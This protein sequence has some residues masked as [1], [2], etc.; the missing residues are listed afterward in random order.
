MMP[1]KP[2]EKEM[3]FIDH[4]EE[5]RKRILKALVAV[6][7]FAVAAYFISD[8][9]I[10]I[11]TAPLRD[12]GVYFKAPTEAFMVRIKISIFAGA[13][14]AAPVVFYQLWMFIG[15]G[16]L[17]K[18]IKIIVAIVLSATVFF[19]AGGAFC[20]FLVVPVAV[21]LLLGFATENM[22]P[23]IMVGDYIS[24]VGMLVLAFGAVFELP[25]ASFILGR[26]GVISHKTLS[27]GRRYAL[28][29]I[30]IAA[31]ILTPTPDAF[32]QLMLAGPLYILYEISIIVVRLTGKRRGE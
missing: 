5:L 32:S 3:T 21:K 13:L 28:V 30:L 4:L 1:D 15:P 16:L 24:F 2:P 20:F 25:V 6:G 22:K 7:I 31:A 10:D 26:L 19:L 29:V 12:V 27:S 23:M 14:A 17:R 18:E 9:L 8:R 11:I